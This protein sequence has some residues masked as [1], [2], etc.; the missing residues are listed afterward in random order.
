M[1]ILRLLKQNIHDNDAI[2]IDSWQNVLY[3]SGFTGY[4][5]A[6]LLVTEKSQYIF[7]DSRYTVQAKLQCPNFKLVLS[8]KYAL[9]RVKEI[10]AEENIKKV[11]FEENGIS[12][13]AYE[14]FYKKLD[15]E[16]LPASKIFDNARETKT[17]DEIEKIET[18][19]DIAAKALEKTMEFIKPGVKE[20]DV[21]ARLEYEMRIRGA[22]REAF[23]TIVASGIRGSMPHGTATEKII[24]KGDAVTIDF[25][26][27]YKGYCSDCTRTFF[28]GTTDPKMKNIY[29]IVLK[30]QRAAL[31]GYEDGMEAR[32]LD[33]IARDIISEAGYGK[34]FGHATGH[35]VGI[36][37]HEGVTVSTR[38][39]QKLADGMVFSVEPGIY[40]EGLG[41]VRI[42][43]LV[44]TQNGTLKVLTKSPG[45]DLIIL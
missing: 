34:E 9:E 12:Y 29:E 31:N 37:V 23:P 15:V 3:V 10:L 40:V 22:E 19:C 11:A 2:I 14:N 25:G 13:K 30:A 39:G 6:L 16:L 18:A 7:T 26:A 17:K 24:E 8:R 32:E 33:K 5:D 38:S 28:V 20:T 43:D 27:F 36:D 41:G 1:D 35:G 21:A 44:T 42:E 45:T 4:D